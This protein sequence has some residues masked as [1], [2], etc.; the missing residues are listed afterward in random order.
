MGRSGHVTVL[1][2]SAAEKVSTREIREKGSP[3]AAAPSFTLGLGVGTH[4]LM[5]L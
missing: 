3:G 5:L 2:L 4:I 1:D